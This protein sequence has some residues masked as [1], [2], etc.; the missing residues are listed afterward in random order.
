VIRKETSGLNQQ[1]YISRVLKSLSQE[2]R[3]F[4]KLINVTF[5][6]DVKTT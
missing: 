1:Q 4:A 6:Y 3:K 2:I 5:H